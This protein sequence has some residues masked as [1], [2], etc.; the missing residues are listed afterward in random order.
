ML[1]KQSVLGVGSVIGAA[2][3]ALAWSGVAGA[4]GATT[5]SN[6]SDSDCM[7][8][9][10]PISCEARADYNEAITQFDL[11]KE[12]NL[13]D[14]VA[15]I[16]YSVVGPGGIVPQ[17]PHRN[18]PCFEYILQGTVTE[19][20][21]YDDGR[22]VVHRVKQDE[23][24]LST[25]DITHWWKNETNS[26]VRIIA[27]DIF[28][29]PKPVF[30]KITAAPRSTFFS[31][32][33]NSDRIKV[34]A[35]GEIDLAVE[36][37]TMPEAKGYIMRSRRLTLEPHQ[38]SE[39]YKSKGQPGYTYVVKGNVLEHRSDQDSAIRRPEE[40]IVTEGNISYYWE[41]PTSEPVVL[42]VVDFVKRQ[43]A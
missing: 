19:T 42:W 40:F 32:P 6:A 5:R 29:D 43:P 13:Q 27:I 28:F 41:N 4:A 9:Q 14:R 22:L 33:A 8:G 31:P 16:H 26:M 10:F 37:P 12:I 1:M 25:S 30:W 21:R 18:R 17:H 36:Y 11:V 39:V 23:V 34:E 7:P 35:M 38:R 15:R 20:K 2:F 24:E 3:I